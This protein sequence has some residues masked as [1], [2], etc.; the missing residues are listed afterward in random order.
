MRK[1]P[2]LM[3][4]DKKP[5]YEGAEVFRRPDGTLGVNIQRPDFHE[6]YSCN[7]ANLNRVLSRIGSELDFTLITAFRAKEKKTDDSGSPV[8]LSMARNSKLSTEL[9]LNMRDLLPRG[10]VRAYSL[11]GHWADSNP[12]GAVTNNLEESWVLVKENPDIKGETWLTA[13]LLL[14]EQFDQD[15]FVLRSNGEITV[16]DQKGTALSTLSG[17]EAVVDAWK[18]LARLRAA[19]QSHRYSELLK[20]NRQ[21]L[22][23]PPETSSYWVRGK[24]TPCDLEFFVRRPDGSISSLMIFSYRGIK[25]QV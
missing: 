2:L 23:L 11:I 20:G 19:G 25:H 4:E 7:A 14:A 16:R 3:L 8:P 1:R 9:Q 21:P 24:D 18:N 15:A 12:D 6:S 10:S 22:P 17:D 13:T 5:N